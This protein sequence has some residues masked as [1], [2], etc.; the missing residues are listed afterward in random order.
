MVMQD[1][2]NNMASPEM[3][4]L[5]QIHQRRSAFV[6]QGGGAPGGPASQPD[7]QQAD[8]AEFAGRQMQ[9]RM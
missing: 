1:F 7:P 5:R 9:K 6:S 3:D 8:F 4:R 2:K